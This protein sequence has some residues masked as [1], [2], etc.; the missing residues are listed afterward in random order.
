M[1]EK[2]APYGLDV[3]LAALGSPSPTPAG[4]SAAAVA[5]A[6]AASLCEMVALIPG[7]RFPE[8]AALAETA[9]E[10]RQSLARLAGE[11]AGAFEELLASRR[12][13]ASG[14]PDPARVAAAENRVVEVPLDIGRA[15]AAVG[16]LARHLAEDGLAP[17]RG[18]CYAACL[19]AECAGR[20]AAA[21]VRLNLA[22]VPE[23]PRRGEALR[24]E[25]ALAEARTGVAAAMT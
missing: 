19:L 10:L 25:E 18:D 9:A 24:L 5:G 7:P 20:I 17:L 6:A 16:D 11:D 15:A 21:L 14:E 8:G 4:G 22:E 23:D 12:S 13:S 3:F 1:A 2:G